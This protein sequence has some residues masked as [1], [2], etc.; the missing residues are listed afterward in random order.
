M[1]TRVVV[2]D[3]HL[4]VRA[5][6]TTLLGDIHDVEVVGEASD[7]AEAVKRVAELNPDI[8]FLDLTMPGMSGFEVLAHVNEAQPGVRIVILS[9]HDTPEHVLRA[10]KLGASGYML[11]DVFPDELAQAIRAVNKGDTWLSSAISK[12]VVAGYLGRSDNEGAVLPQLTTR[13]SQVLKMIAEGH[14][15]KQISSDLNLSIKTI[16]TYRA[17]IMD[18]LDIHDVAG[19]VRYAIRHGIS[20]L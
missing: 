14:S 18:K 2:A 9:M 8:L 1:G 13:Q 20:P 3:D 15:T 10:L 17:Q 7:G 5:G 6:I 12:T 11:K 19:L 4:L 16:E